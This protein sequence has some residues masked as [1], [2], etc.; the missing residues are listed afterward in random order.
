MINETI[1]RLKRAS[2]GTQHLGSRY[3]RLLKRLWRKG[4]PGAAPPSPDSITGNDPSTS[5]LY[6]PSNAEAMNQTANRRHLGLQTAFDPARASFH[7]ENE[8]QPPPQAGPARMA[9]YDFNWLD[10]D[11]VGQFA[12]DEQVFDG[13]EGMDVEMM[14][15]GFGIESPEFAVTEDSESVGP[16]GA[17]LFF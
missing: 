2:V 14:W 15:Y 13:G 10:L 17:S 5:N 11:A 16:A 4:D 12:L 9:N 6:N 8:M 1:E 3:A 7:N